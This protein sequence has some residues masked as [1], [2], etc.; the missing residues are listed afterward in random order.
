MKEYK[1][2][3]RAWATDIKLAEITDFLTLSY[4]KQVNQAGFCTFTLPGDHDAIQYLTDNARVD[5]WRRDVENA[6]PWNR[7]FR[8]L[9][10]DVVRSHK[11]IENLFVATCPGRL[12]ILGWREILWHTGVDNRTKFTNIRAETIMKTLVE[13]NAG[14][15]AT[16]VN[17]RLRIGVVTQGISND[18]DDAGGNLITWECAYENLLENL[19]KLQLV[20]GGD[21][22]LEDDGTGFKF[23]WYEVH[24]G[25][26]RTVGNGINPEVLFSTDNRNMADPIYTKKLSTQKTVAVVG[27]TGTETAR[28]TET[29]TAND[30]HVDTNNI[31]IFVDARDA[32]T[33]A[34]MQDAGDAALAKTKAQAKIDFTVIQ[35]NSCAYKKHYDLG[36][37]VTVD[38]IENK[39][40]QIKG[41]TVTVDKDRTESIDL[42]LEKYLGQP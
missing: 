38:Y 40:V 32:T 5:V 3:V 26:D 41:L 13:Y 34:A 25:T 15:S 35:T 6:V 27:G 36:D 42:D 23:Y 1:I 20:A 39:N 14:A 24:R 31:E 22:S 7:D 30:Y 17:G 28:D 11:G 10:K 4:R 18:T 8:G 19:Q 21:F 37:L 9:F 29:V 16:V 33:A 2:L 12:S